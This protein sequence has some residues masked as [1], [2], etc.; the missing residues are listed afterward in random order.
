MKEAGLLIKKNRRIGS[1]RLHTGAISVKDSNIGWAS[2]ITSIKCWNRQ[3]LRVAIV[4]DCCDHSIA[5]W[6]AGLHMQ[7]FD[8]ELMVK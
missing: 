5:S 2:D 6:K 4:I 1:N 7:A 8:I 3:K